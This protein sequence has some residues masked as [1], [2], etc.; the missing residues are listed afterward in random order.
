[1]MGLDTSFKAVTVF[2]GCISDFWACIS[3]SLAKTQMISQKNRPQMITQVFCCE[4]FPNLGIHGVFFE[5]F[6]APGSEC[7]KALKMHSVGHFP[8]R[9]PGLL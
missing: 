4:W 2:K 1:M 6:W 3:D 9:A 8:A 7:P 5:C